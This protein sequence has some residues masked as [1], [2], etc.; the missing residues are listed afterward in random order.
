MTAGPSP[1]STSWRRCSADRSCSTTRRGSSHGIPIASSGS[2]L[3]IQGPTT[4]GCTHR[5][6]TTRDCSVVCV[7]P[8]PSAFTDEEVYEFDMWL[9][10]LAGSLFSAGDDL[11]FDRDPRNFDK[12]LELARRSA[13]HERLHVLRTDRLGGVCGSGRAGHTAAI[14]LGRHRMGSRMSTRRARATCVSSATGIRLD[15]AATTRSRGERRSSR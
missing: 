7:G 6:P 2:L 3:P 15:A 11:V 14:R 8:R 9:D 4:R 5:R 1:D 13:A 10:A 12:G